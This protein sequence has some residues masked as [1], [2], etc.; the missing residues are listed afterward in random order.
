MRKSD[1]FEALRCL[2][3]ST[4][5]PLYLYVVFATG[6][7]R[8]STKRISRPLF[9]NAMICMRS[10]IVCARNSVSSKTEASGQKVTVV[11]VR[12]SPVVR[13][14]GAG[15]TA[16]IFFLSLPP[17]S[18]SAS[19]CLPSRSTSRMTRVERALTTEIPTPWR[20]PETW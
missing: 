4:M 19:Q 14:F 17:F 9:K 10:T 2:T 5:P 18:N 11:P 20:P 16:V 15:P 12:G 1:S 8:S 7:V 3:K 13:S 6:S